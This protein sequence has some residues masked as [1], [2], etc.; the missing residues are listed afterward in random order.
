MMNTLW[1]H[2]YMEPTEAEVADVFMAESRN[3]LHVRVD[4]F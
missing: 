2:L 1:R 3:D 4:E